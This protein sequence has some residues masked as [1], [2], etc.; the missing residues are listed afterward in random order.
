[1]GKGSKPRNCFSKSFRD[2]FDE[3]DWSDSKDY[4]FICGE[5]I[6]LTL[7][8]LNPELFLSEGKGKIRHKNCTKD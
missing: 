3:I 2:N 4:C 8:A 6:N 1:M 5:E 7:M